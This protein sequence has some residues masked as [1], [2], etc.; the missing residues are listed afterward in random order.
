MNQLCKPVSILLCLAF[1]CIQKNASAQLNANFSASPLSGCAPL[2][3]NFTDL[4]TGGATSWRWD[5][6]NGTVST[7]Q[8]PTGSYF[9]A[10]TYSVKLVIENASGADSITRNQYIT[11]FPKPVVAFT[12]SETSACLPRTIQF[13]DQSTTPGGSITNWLWDFGDG[14]TSSQPNPSHIFSTAGNFTVS[15]QVTNNDGCVTV[16]TKPTYINIANKP[17]ANFSNT[18]PSVCAVS[19]S[20]NFTNLSTGQG[21]LTYQWQFGDGGTSTL[22]N[23]SHIYTVPG[24]YTVQLITISPFGCSDTIIKP[25]LINVG[26]IQSQFTYPANA[27][28]GSAISVTNT[29]IPVPTNSNWNFGDGTTATG[30]S[31]TKTYAAPGMY[32]I[33]LINDYG[34]CKDTI[35]H[36]ITVNPKPTVSFIADKTSSC[37]SPLTVTFNATTT[38]TTYSWNFGDGD[39]SAVEDPVHIYTAPGTYTVRLIVRNA[40]GCSDTLTRTNYISILPPTV[41]V[42]GLPRIGCAP[43]TILPVP[44]VTSTEP[45]TS[46]LWNFGDGGTSNSA[47]PTYTYNTAGTYTVS[48]T[49]ATASGCTATITLTDAVRAGSKPNANFVVNPSDV[50]A[51]DPV[52]FTNTSTPS[53]DQ[54]LWDFGDGGTSTVENPTYIYT[55]TGYFDVTLIVW[56]NTCP[57]TIVYNDIVHIRPPIAQFSFV[58]SCQ[59]KLIKRFIDNSIGALSWAWDFGDGGSSTQQNPLHSYAAPGIYNVALTVTNGPCTFTYTQPVNVV[60]ELAVIIADRD[61]ICRNSSV[62]FTA[63]SINTTNISGWEWNFGDG[64]PVSTIADSASH[65][66]TVSGTYTAVLV[67][68]DMNG[69]VDSAFTTITVYG[70][71]ANFS[72]LSPSICLGTGAVTF[73]DLSTTDGQHSILQWDW[74]YGD[75]NSGTFASAPFQHTY[76]SRGSYAVYLKITDQYGCTDSITKVNAIIVSKPIADFNSPDTVTCTN[77]PIVFN[78][79]TLANGPTYTWH[80]GDASTSTQ[81]NPVHSYSNTGIYTVELDV[82]DQYGCTDTLIRT[83]YINISVPVAGFLVSDTFSSCPPL[84]VGFTSQA[85]GNLTV[86]WDFGDGNSSS[87]TDPIH[88]YTVAGVYFAKQYVSGPGGCIDSISRRIEI[89]G[90]SGVFNY[91]PIGGCAPVN[92]TFTATAQNHSSILWDFTDGSTATTVGNTITHSYNSM[93]D[94][95]PRMILIDSGGCTVPVLGVDS[96]HVSGVTVNFSKTISSTCDAGTVDFTNLTVTNGTIASWLWNFGDGT[97][98]AAQHPQHIYT[99]PGTYPVRLRAITIE[100][101]RDSLLVADTIRIHARPLISING[102]DSACIPASVQLTGIVN[103]GNP[104]LLSWDWTM[105]NGFI[106]S[107]QSSL[108][109]YINAGSYT[110]TAIATNEFGCRDTANKIFVANPLPNTN[111][112][113]D[114]IICLGTPVQLTATGATTY[115]WDPAPFISCTNC[116]SPLANPPDNYLYIV[117][118]FNQFGCTRSDSVLV[119]V[120]KPFQMA[121]SLTDTL[122]LGERSQLS[123]S[124]ADFYTW[125]PAS[126]LNNST[127]PNPLASPA[128]TTVYTVIGRDS[129]NCFQ[130]TAD[131]TVRV[132]PI[133]VVDAGIDLTV[134]AGSPIRLNATASADV[135]KYLW[136]PAFNISCPTCKDPV[137]TTGKDMKFKLEVKND[138][139]CTNTDEV[140]VFVTCNNGNLF[141]PN[142]FSPNG[143]GAND[144]FYPRGKGISKIQ[145][146]RVFNRWGELVFE[147]MNFL[148]NDISMGWNGTYKGQKLTADVFIYTCDVVCENNVVLPYKGDIM[149]LR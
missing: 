77:K 24:S 102:P 60:N 116:S 98:S 85:T 121:N 26:S 122:C 49:I 137:V 103:S 33:R 20:V 15:L 93:G 10:G 142:T 132:F 46:Y 72:A 108:Q 94:Y 36:S 3:V 128:T 87:L 81:A 63:P 75:G 47:T 32:T 56:N 90:P 9:N 44:T 131:I 1:F 80:F 143:D 88:N 59:Q 117:K 78:N 125:S 35:T 66:Y 133:P 62:N 30:L 45:I 2:V 112:G 70:P 79:T 111:A 89:R 113:A 74:Q 96:I 99:S 52:T 64:S 16:L 12:A 145:S 100:G 123:A 141:I 21:T 86:N 104:A 134:S 149:L 107:V 101:C 8:N 13:T 71:T 50:C 17:V 73:N 106:D 28:V 23:P 58:D 129:S 65:V 5:L 40:N 130:D 110:I 67:I 4:S 43:L 118:G 14:T 136:T 119:R 146:L 139:G 27:C 144:I 127:I 76:I 61:T 29:T 114:T 7:L 135:T 95:L 126:T 84:Q 6:G 147:K 19:P 37:Q 92:V 115:T 57:D 48:L 31:P 42:A 18:I 83:D 54:W 82:R 105:G 22:T 124:G 38:G 53:T 140:S 55:D 41:T 11:V 39:S 25:Q 97:T 51:K 91:T 68:T 109:S 148:P 69:C 34:A 138:G 120:R